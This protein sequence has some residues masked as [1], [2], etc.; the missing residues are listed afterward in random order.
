MQMIEKIRTSY[1]RL[2]VPAILV[3][4]IVASI[5]WFPYNPPDRDT[6]EPSRG[7][8][9]LAPPPVLELDEGVLST[10]QTRTEHNIGYVANDYHNAIYIVDL[11]TREYL[12]R[13]NFIAEEPRGG[14]DSIALTPDKE[15]FI[16]TRGKYSNDILVI[17]AHNYSLVKQIPGGKYNG[18]IEVNSL[19]NEAYILSGNYQDTNLYILDLESFSISDKINIGDD[20]G[21]LVLSGSKLFVT[22]KKGISFIDTLT[23]EITETVAMNTSSWKRVV[24]HPTRPLIYVV[25]NPSGDN[26]YPLVQVFDMETGENVQNIKQLTN[27]KTP[28]GAITCIALSPDG[29]ELYCV[30]QM[31]EL[32]VVNT[33][34][35]C[36]IINKSVKQPDYYGKPDWVYFNENGSKAYLI[37]WG[38]VAID[39]PVPDSPSIIGVLDTDSY[40]FTDI[41]E[42]D[43]HAGLGMMTVIRHDSTPDMHAYIM[44]NRY[45]YSSTPH[46]MVTITEDILDRSHI[47]EEA[48]LVEARSHAMGLA[49]PIEWVVCTD[50]EGRAVEELIE[51]LPSTG[52]GS[53]HLEYQGEKYQ[54]TV[55]YSKE[56]PTIL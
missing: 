7:P 46:T 40:E 27:E 38:G 52:S 12:G 55:K 20:L 6:H 41:I 39:T 47:L 8:F 35:Y 18:Y 48:F 33:T 19:L 26:R 30:S 53:I 54:F 5:I 50:E 29:A 44:V 37:Y 43:E 11:T 28:D 32:V 14:P 45:A 25:N 21:H 10:L 56:A 2:L 23:R 16:V 24:A 42:F 15:Y 51:S 36:R 31:N 3:F 4:V 34:D 13:L 49:H 22:T 17:D 9:D 1:R